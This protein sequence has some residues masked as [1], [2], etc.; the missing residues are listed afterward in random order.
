MSRPDGNRTVAVCAVRAYCRLMPPGAGASAPRRSA[1]DTDRPR[2]DDGPEP[3]PVRTD[4]AGRNKRP[5]PAAPVPATTAPPA[6]PMNRRRENMDLAGDVRRS[7]VVLTGA[8]PTRAVSNAPAP[9]KAT[10]I[11][12]VLQVSG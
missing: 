1:T 12:A 2:R 3:P 4:S 7:R 9:T 5:T 8:A 10:A 11:N 6:N